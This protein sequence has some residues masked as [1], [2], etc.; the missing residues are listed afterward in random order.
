MACPKE[1]KKKTKTETT[2]KAKNDKD[3]DI[4]SDKGTRHG[5]P[6]PQGPAPRG[7]ALL[8]TGCLALKNIILAPPSFKELDKSWGTI[9]EAKLTTEDPKIKILQSSPFCPKGNK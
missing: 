2:T 3:N 6:T 1:T 7:P 4:Q 5:R 9:G 8:K